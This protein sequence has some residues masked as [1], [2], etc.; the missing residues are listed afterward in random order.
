M[1]LLLLLV[2]CGP[3]PT[4]PGGTPADP[5]LDGPAE[6][7]QPA[8]QEAGAPLAVRAEA[9]IVV[10]AYA[11]ANGEG[12]PLTDGG[13]VWFRES[14]SLWTAQLW[15]DFHNCDVRAE[16]WFVGWYGEEPISLQAILEICTEEHPRTTGLVDLPKRDGL[17]P[18]DGLPLLLTIEAGDS[19][20]DDAISQPMAESWSVISAVE[21][22]SF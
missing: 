22:S 20:F 14:E 17:D 11:V 3:T 12:T 15:L 6:G 5:A 1:F 4:A 10:S 19:S 7:P 2:A 18:A 9:P 21:P 16:G 8:E 13:T